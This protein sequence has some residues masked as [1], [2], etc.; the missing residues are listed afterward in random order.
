MSI[1]DRK[2]LILASSSPRRQELIRTLR[3][4]YEI[5]VSDVN[6]DTGPGLAPAEIVEQLSGRKAAAVCEMY[7]SELPE[8]G[9]IIGSDTVVVLE[10]RVLGKPRDERDA[11]GMLSALQ[12]RAHH[13]YSGVALLDVATGQTLVDHQ[14]TAVYMKPLT[15]GQI[16]RYIRTGEPMDKAGSYAIQG[17]GATIVERI[18]GDYFNVVGLPISL[19]S[20]LLERLGITVL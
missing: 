3:L 20:E 15:G 2:K 18:E 5:R 8:N 17:L 12:G 11:F 9:I 10:G 16:E 1:K 7:K 6:E 19:L 14:V 4:P 13:V